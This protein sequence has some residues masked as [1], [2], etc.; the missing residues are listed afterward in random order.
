[1]KI[2]AQKKSYSIDQYLEQ[3]AHHAR[4]RQQEVLRREEDAK[5][6]VA[7]FTQLRR[8]ELQR[9]EV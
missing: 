8:E 6:R 7:N 5:K 3:E 2:T 4:D 9:R 1:M